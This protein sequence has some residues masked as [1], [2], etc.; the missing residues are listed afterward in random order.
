MTLGGFNFC[1]YKNLGCKKLWGLAPSNFYFLTLSAL[2]LVFSSLSQAHETSLGFEKVF[3]QQNVVMLMIDPDSGKIVEANP[4]A[5]KF[6]GYPMQSLE[7]MT[8]QQINLLPKKQVASDRKSASAEDKNTFIFQHKLANGEV[9]TVE[10]H[11]EPYQV[12]GKTLLLSMV[13]DITEERSHSKG[14]WAYQTALEN[15]VHFQK[16]QLAQEKEKQIYLLSGGI[17]LQMALIGYLLYDIRRRKKLQHKL[18]SVAGTLSQIMNAATEVSIVATDTKGIITKFNSGAQKLL[19]YTE[20]E[21]VGKATPGA[22]HLTK[23]VE[24]KK[25]ILEKE[26][27]PIESDM[28]VFT[29]KA[30]EEG[31]NQGEWTFIDKNGNHILVSLVVTPIYAKNGKEVIGYL[32]VA[33]DIGELKKSEQALIESQNQLKATLDA[34]PDLLFEVSND[35]VILNYHTAAEV[36]ELYIKPAEFLGKTYQEILPQD[37]VE[38]CDASFEEAR[39]TGRSIGKQ[40]HMQT[41]DG[42]RYFELSVS[43]KEKREEGYSFVV[44]S[45][46]ITA[47]VKAQNH[48]KLISNVFDY[49]REGITITDSQGNII[50][51][52]KGFSE[53]TGYSREEVL[54][55]NPRMLKSNLQPPD[56][57]KD[58]WTDI[59]SKGYWTGEMWNRHK[60]GE[61]Y[62]EV[63]TISAIND[64]NGQPQNYMGIFTDVTAIK[65]NQQRLE[66]IAHYDVLTQLPNRVLLADRLQQAIIHADRN[67]SSLAVL[68]VDLDGFKEVN[69]LY[70]HDVGDQLLMK[71]SEKMQKSLR[72]EDTLARLGGDE[73]VALLVDLDSAQ[74]SEPV[75]ERVL[76]SVSEPILI[77]GALIK[78][79]A[80][81]GV[82]LYPNDLS[83]ADLLIRHADQAMYQAKQEGKNRFRFFDVDQD[84]VVKSQSAMLLDIRVAL[85]EDQFVLHYQPK[86]DLEKEEICG[87]EALIRWQH[88]EKGLLY[89]D[90]FLPIVNDHSLSIEIDEWVMKEAMRQWEEWHDLGLDMPISVNIGARSLQQKDF[91]NRI[92][93]CF[94]RYPG[95]AERALQFEVLETTALEEVGNVSELMRY[96]QTLGVEF[97]LD[98]FGTGYSSLTYLRH[99]PAKLI[100]I[101]QSFVRDMLVDKD[102]LAIVDGVLKLTQA[103]GRDVIAEGVE[104]IEHCNK[105]YQMGCCKVQ[106]YAI[107]RPIPAES[108]PNWIEVVSEKAI[109]HIS[110]LAKESK[111][112]TLV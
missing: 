38:V 70:G 30:H 1:L 61:V 23:E 20:D 18:N 91:K 10:V 78:V 3:N 80:S 49:A 21:M 43:C 99:L 2:L 13:N 108:L 97:A 73:F 11:S 31:G 84:A 7:Q 75:L 79:S 65:Q 87:V 107:A 54:G 59:S 55:K 58:M 51:V 16:N 50:D 62:A 8:I 81:I 27:G 25:A 96:C 71:I 9:R 57:Y 5:A 42:I 6:Y 4:A 47:R 22:F 26:F 53:I 85:R 14:L 17:L 98:D 28:Q 82:A 39:L 93:T 100:K 33:R 77:D 69:D 104:T 103:F 12:K 92:E 95:I 34:I 86:A 88:P 74:A 60:N 90:E 66:H 41:R 40:Y 15:I 109:K 76:Y 52:N 36:E 83:D 37:V 68:F 105:L 19:G 106:G 64:D 94:S 110:K 111:A 24:Q 101:D 48:L 46:D 35:G 67:E 102:D 56:F 44:L 63:I 89:P 72:A 32:G 112:S 29:L 45:R